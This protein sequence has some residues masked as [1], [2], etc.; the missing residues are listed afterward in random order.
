VTAVATASTAAVVLLHPLN[1]P[2]RTAQRRPCKTR[3]PERTDANLTVSSAAAG[4][5]SLLPS[6]AGPVP[7]C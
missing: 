4:C 7:I 1:A 3:L 2:A 5:P 6:D